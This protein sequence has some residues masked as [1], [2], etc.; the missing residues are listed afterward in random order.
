MVFGMAGQYRNPVS[1]DL[2][3]VTPDESSRRYLEP[4]FRCLR[5]KR[6]RSRASA[7]TSYLEHCQRRELA[8]NPLSLRAIWHFPPGDRRAQHRRYARLPGR[9]GGRLDAT[10]NRVI[11]VRLYAWHD[12]RNADER[13]FN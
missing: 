1:V 4:D 13:S 11:C 6:R 9:Q 2:R 12:V 5:C 10:P 7:R 8:R 3:Y